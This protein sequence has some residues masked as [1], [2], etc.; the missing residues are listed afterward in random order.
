MLLKIGGNR[1]EEEEYRSQRAL[2]FTRL[3][4]LPAAVVDIVLVV[5]LATFEKLCGYV[6]FLSSHFASFSILHH[7]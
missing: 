2:V 5:D 7:C 1:R 3:T 6:S 4:S